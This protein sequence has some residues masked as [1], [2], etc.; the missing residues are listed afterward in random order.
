MDIAVGE[1]CRR[2][3]DK[4]GTVNSRHPALG[5]LRCPLSAA[6]KPQPCKRALQPL[7]TSLRPRCRALPACRLL[8]CLPCMLLLLRLLRVRLPLLPLPL[9]LLRLR[10]LLLRLLRPLLARLPAAQ[11]PLEVQDGQHL[12]VRL[13]LQRHPRLEAS[14]LHEPHEPCMGPPGCGGNS[15]GTCRQLKRGKLHRPAL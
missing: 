7:P 2:G 3:N 6:G 12:F 5:R 1:A 4:P 13:A 11:P 8:V 14:C 15:A 10:L 9:L